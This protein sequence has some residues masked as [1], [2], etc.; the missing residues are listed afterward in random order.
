[1]KRVLITG[2][3]TGLGKDAAISLSSRGHYVYATTHTLEEADELNKI[4][5]ENHLPLE[6][7]K[8]DIL[9]A[10]ERSLVDNLPIDVLINNAAIGDSGSVC[11]INVDT[12][13]QTFET[14]VFSSIEL[15]QRVLKNMIRKGSGRIIFISSLSGR[16]TLPFLSPYTAT[17]FAIESIA[18]SLKKE[19]REL[20]SADIDVTIIEPGAYATGFN[21]KN[22][23]KQFTWM[24]KGSYF[25]SNIDSLEKKQFRY[26]QLNETENT[27]SIINEYIKAVEDTKVKDR[28][29]APCIQ[30]TFIQIKR[31]LGK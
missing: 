11:E 2:S 18:I 8:L 29:V 20:K 23:S 31:I 17:K 22:I 24:R 28:Y 3:G 12:Y 1:M 13:R 26:F 14:N 5:K 6:S 7:F 9:S 4:S 19:L 27:N 16:V 30:G 25:G 21:Q 15:T 10:S